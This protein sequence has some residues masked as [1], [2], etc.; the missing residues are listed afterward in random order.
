MGETKGYLTKSS[1]R[2]KKASPIESSKSPKRTPAENLK[3][4]E[5]AYY[6]K[7]YKN[8]R[9]NTKKLQPF[10]YDNPDEQTFYNELKPED[11][12]YF[13]KGMRSERNENT[14][15]AMLKK[16]M[17]KIAAENWVD[18]ELLEE[19]SIACLKNLKDKV[20]EMA[21]KHADEMKTFNRKL[22]VLN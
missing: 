1:S 14:I 20:K 6:K 8:A 18:Y 16:R 9:N 12:V 11:P 5:D 7:Y 22:D 19:F 2:K 10:L 21:M 15:D 13:M 17:D 3:R 4:Y